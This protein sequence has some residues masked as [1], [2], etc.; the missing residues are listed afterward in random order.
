MATVTPT[1]DRRMAA[2]AH[3]DFDRVRWGIIYG[4]RR[5]FE[6][7]GMHGVFDM[8]SIQLRIVAR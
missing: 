2:E 3:F 6:H 5:F 4:S 7:L 8:I 1:A